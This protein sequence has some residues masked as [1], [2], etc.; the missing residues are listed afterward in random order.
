MFDNCAFDHLLEY[1]S[2]FVDF[3][4]KTSKENRYY[5]TSVQI[6]EIAQIED[7]KKEIRIIKTLCLTAMRPLII[8]TDFV[9]DECRFGFFEFADDEDTAFENI[10]GNSSKMIHDAMIGAAAKRAACIVV[11][12]DKKLTKRL[13]SEN[14]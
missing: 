7:D 12:D 4:N 6:E 11:T 9:F 2:D 3:F 1:T 13:A 14:I 10:K 5:T 8:N